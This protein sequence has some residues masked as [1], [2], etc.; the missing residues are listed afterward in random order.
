MGEG[1][2]CGSHSPHMGMTVLGGEGGEGEGVVDSV[3]TQREYA[4]T[5]HEICMY[6]ALYMHKRC[7]HYA[8]YT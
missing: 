6:R 5:M 2:T 7:L 8:W 1:D 4:C 3:I